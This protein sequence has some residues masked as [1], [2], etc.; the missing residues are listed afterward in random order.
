MHSEHIRGVLKSPVNG[1]PS[2]RVSCTH[3]K[4]I[5]NQFFPS[6]PS[7]SVVVLT[8]ISCP[9]SSTSKY[10]RM[11]A[12]LILSSPVFPNIGSRPSEIFMKERFVRFLAFFVYKGSPAQRPN[13]NNLNTVH[14]NCTFP[15]YLLTYEK[16]MVLLYYL[17]IFKLI[18]RN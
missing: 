3:L 11:F 17:L 5:F 12:T 14:I 7:T 18:L 6:H 15:T 4:A 10:H 2:L 8:N 1:S 16:Q 9:M 13:G